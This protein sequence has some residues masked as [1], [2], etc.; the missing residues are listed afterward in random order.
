MDGAARTGGQRQHMAMQP[1]PWKRRE[2][3][4]GFVGATAFTGVS[5][6]AEGR[7]DA[8][9]GDGFML[10]RDKTMSTKRKRENGESFA[11]GR[12]RRDHAGSTRNRPVQSQRP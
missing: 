3:A 8:G 9:R 2:T 7:S 1:S 5:F 4:V 10:H 6:D 12:A 11:S